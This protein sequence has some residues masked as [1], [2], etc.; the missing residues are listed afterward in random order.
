MLGS[1][2]RKGIGGLATRT[3][4][5]AKGRPS[6]TNQPILPESRDSRPGFGVGES[7]Q[8]HHLVAFGTYLT[9][10]IPAKSASW[11]Q[12][13]APARRAVARMI[14][15]A[16][17]RSLACVSRAASSAS[18]DERGI[19]RPRP[20]GAATR[21]AS[22]SPR[23]RSTTRN[24]SQTLTVGSTSRLS[25]ASGSANTLALAPSVKNSILRRAARTDRAAAPS[26]RESRNRRR[27]SGSGP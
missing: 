12:S 14:P 21:S 27:P 5:L 9:W 1:E 4:R 15:S 20:I 26:R 17:A 23:R 19:S 25:S 24:T 18:A 8:P 13:V 10:G 16:I 6:L 11:V 7:P 2:P 22:S 3:F